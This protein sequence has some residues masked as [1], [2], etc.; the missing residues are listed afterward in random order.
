MISLT[1]SRV[2]CDHVEDG[3]EDFAAC[4]E[5]L[6]VPSARSVRDLTRAALA[7]GWLIPLP[8]GSQLCPAH[9]PSTTPK[10]PT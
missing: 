1:G 2:W 8:S 6:V 9:R 5:S 4:D 7:A 10:D 3:G